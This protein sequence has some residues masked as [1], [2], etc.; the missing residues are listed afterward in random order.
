MPPRRLGLLNQKQIII[1]KNSKMFF[2]PGRGIW[3]YTYN[4]FHSFFFYIILF[5]KCH[6]STYGPSIPT[7]MTQCSQGVVGG[8]FLTFYHSFISK[9]SFVSYKLSDPSPLI[10]C[11]PSLTLIQPLHTCVFH[12]CCM[13]H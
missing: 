5:Q 7:L 11:I 9:L 6:K 1:F 10:K 13:T 12:A 8:R 2:I 4:S 3:N